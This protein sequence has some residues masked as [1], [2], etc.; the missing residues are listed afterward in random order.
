MKYAVIFPGQGAQSVGMM[1]EYANCNT[2]RETFNTAKKVLGIDLWDIQAN[3]DSQ[4]LAKT[5]ITQP[6]LLTAG[7][8]VYRY[9][10]EHLN[11]PPSYAAGHSLGE[12]CALVV[13]ESINFENALLVVN[14][15]AQLMESTAKD[16]IG[17]MA[18]VLNSTK[19]VI[20]NA[21]E[22]ASGNF[23]GEEQS[24]E[25][26]NYN[27]PEQIVI[28][29]HKSAVIRCCEILKSQGVKRTI[30]LSVS[31]AFHSKL[32]QGASDAMIEVLAKTEVNPPK[33]PVFH[34]VD[35]NS[36]NN[37]D[38]IRKALAM[39][40]ASPVRWYEIIQKFYDLGIRNIIESSPSKVLSGLNKKIAVE[41]NSISLFTPDDCRNTSN[42]LIKE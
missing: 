19:D 12:Y 29:G 40:V 39:Q 28:A 20:I 13:A 25:A 23:D 10:Q 24:V 22:E 36:Y 31:G 21:C 11:I 6:L 7:V 15:R 4:K 32:M 41:L 26:V 17:A 2:V 5:T 42:N 35:L 30:L 9:F 8:A 38:D 27:S 34:N 33:I 18:A 16:S 14:Q 3:A 37:P 1:N